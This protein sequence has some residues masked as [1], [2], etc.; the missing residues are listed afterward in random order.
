MYNRKQICQLAGMPLEAF[1]HAAKTDALPISNDDETPVSGYARYTALDATVL[2]VAWAL[3]DAGGYMT[4]GVPFPSAA[5]VAANAPIGLLVDRYRSGERGLFV[6]YAAFSPLIG[7]GVNVYGSLAEIANE[8]LI[9]GR[10][11]YARLYLVDLCQ[12]LS[13]IRTRAAEH[14]IAFIPADLA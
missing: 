5:K 7:G 10:D 11:A 4:E 6:G 9:K 8:A 2:A 14:G 13:D 1:K 12:T 3:R